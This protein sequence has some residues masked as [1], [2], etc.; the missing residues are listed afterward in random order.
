MTFSLNKMCLKYFNV[1]EY[2]LSIS[3][4]ENAGYE[5]VYSIRV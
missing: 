4:S 1:N 5:D 3:L 2:R